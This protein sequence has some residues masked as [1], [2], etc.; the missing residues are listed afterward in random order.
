MFPNHRLNSHI[1]KSTSLPAVF[2]ALLLALCAP[3]LTH[4]SFSQTGAQTGAPNADANAKALADFSSRLPKIERLEGTIET[5]T[6][7]ATLRAQLQFQAPDKLRIEIQEG[8]GARAQTIVASENET[9]FFDPATKRVQRVPYNVARQWW[10]SWNLASGGPANFLLSA[11][12][13]EQTAPFYAPSTPAAGVLSLDAQSDAAK[14][15]APKLISDSV[16][17]G[18]GGDRIFYAPF[19]RRVWNRPAKIAL[20]SPVG[21]AQMIR[22]ETDDNGQITTTTISL[23]A[24]NWPQSASAKD[25]KNRI[26]ADWKYALKPREEAFPEAT[27][28]F[29]FA[30]DIVV[31]DARLQ[32]LKEY[33]GASAPDKFNKGTVLARQ[34]EAWPEAFAA[35][36]ESSRLAPNASAPQLAIY[37]AAIITRDLDRA[38]AAL[39]K[40]QPILGADSFEWNWRNAA[41][42]IARRQWESA[43]TSLET[44]AR[45][46]PQDL[47]V[48][49]TLADLLRARSNFD[50]ARGVLLPILSSELGPNAVQVRAAEMLADLMRNADAGVLAALPNETVW[51]KLARAH[52][53]LQAGKTATLVT[54][55]LD[56]LDSFARGLETAGRGEDA[57]AAWQKIAERAFAD[58]DA[59]LHLMALF[60]R[61]GEIALS[62]SQYRE[63]IAKTSSMKTQN[64]YQDALLGTWR[65]SFRQE[66]LKAVL[67]Q[68]AISTNATEDDAR[69]WLK[70][71]ETYGSNEDVAAAVNGG[72]ARFSRSAW[73][74]SRQAQLLSA[75]LA[76]Y[77]DNITQERIQR[78]VLKAI[79]LAIAFDSSQ[80]YYA[81]QR[82]LILTQRASPPTM[83]ID[84]AKSVP[85]VQAAEDAL[86]ILLKQWP[87]DADVQIAV[88]S[89][90]LALEADGAHA[91]SIALLQSAL[92]EGMP[93]WG[94]DRHFISFS[95][96]QV[97][98]SA[99]RRDGKWA[100][101]TPEYINLFRSSRSAEEELGVALNYLRLMMNREEDEQIAS[102]LVDF[103]RE[104]WS[105]EDSQQLIQPLVN[106]VLSKTETPGVPALADGVLRALQANNS[107]YARLMAAYFLSNKARAARRLAAAAEAPINADILAETAANDL[108][109][110]MKNLT[111]LTENPDHILASR[112]A[113]LLGEDA[114]N[115]S[116]PASAVPFLTRAVALEPRDVNLRVA[117][118]TALLAQSKGEESIALRDDALRALPPSFEVLHQLAKLSYQVGIEADRDNTTRLADAAMNMGLISPEISSGDWQF[119]ALTAA[120][121]NLDAGKTPAASAIY[122]GLAS[123]QWGELDRAVAL[124]DWETNLR[125]LEQ[126]DQ[127]DAIAA[128]LKALELSAVQQQM[129]ES[130]WAAIG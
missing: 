120:R 36:E 43:Q 82:A 113:A 92:R 99:L 12:S 11:L 28:S 20:R 23:D 127:A 2:A 64:E 10:R 27:F 56:A 115:Q 75:P 100:V 5:T 45:L 70:Y 103:A 31:E 80:P 88:A 124:I 30:P 101:I 107:P 79:D 22:E 61:K 91:D 95:S 16:Q 68:R 42:L 62:L 76:S 128:Q 29:D 55:N 18:G 35:W 32:A 38:D 51:Q 25:A 105:F 3:I 112:A 21:K 86:S 84:K 15:E 1:V 8:G 98:L 121:A 52:I 58:A 111:N 6:G 53:D 24:N 73:W 26:I 14:T 129:A 65:K 60:A 4:S 74:R 114:M 123:P 110:S 44:A 69:L 97:L 83:V 116:A 93:D 67:S 130:A 7:G 117:R 72:V 54:E 78:D 122:N 57:I 13:P 89:Q 48:Q 66:Q 90:R 96:R 104:P 46:R 39:A 119:A 81:I 102:A 109:T 50:G 108:A 126:E 59:R 41:V 40:L 106:V 125:N 17:F 19:K 85:L 94:E 37:E 49:L 63:L 47:Q 33:S 34:A 118:A 87:D 9:R 71:Q 77:P